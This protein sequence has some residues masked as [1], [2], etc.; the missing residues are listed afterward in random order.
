V[1][2]EDLRNSLDMIKPD[3]AAKK[4]MLGNILYRTGRH[5]D[6]KVDG[7]RARSLFYRAVPAFA[8]TAVV[9]AGILIYAVKWK[10]REHPQDDGPG[11]AADMAREDAPAMFIDQ[12]QIGNRHYVLLT[13]DLREDYGLPAAVDE[14]DIG[15]EIADIGSSPDKSLTGRGVY[16]YVPAGGEAVV[17]VR[18][19]DGYQLYRFFVFESYNNNQD[20]DA[21]EYLK[22]Y[23]I[24]S[25]EDIAK[26]R[27]IGHSERSKELGVTDIRGEITGR[28]GIMRFYE[29]FSALKNSS[30]KYFDRLFN[31]S[32]TPAGNYSI[33]I[34]I[35]VPSDSGS[36]EI[37]IEERERMAAAE[38]SKGI[39]VPPDAVGPDTAATGQSGNSDIGFASAA[40]VSA[41]VPVSSDDPVTVYPT[42]PANP[43]AS[44]SS[45]GTLTDTGDGMPGSVQGS[46]GSVGNALENAITIRIYN[47]NGIY[48]DTVY[49]RNIGFISRY[50]ISEGFAA[51]I[52]TML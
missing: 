38:A 32:S 21:I 35:S 47:K 50:E 5:E 33:E 52:S 26:I 8:L 27:F 44:G 20:E 13:D 43:S 36:F 30:D 49:Y 34:D 11:L 7:R 51:F 31:Y 1:K 4:R 40:P 3:E 16:R 46:P 42:A 2:K 24:N 39:A 17:A 18:K 23:G 25:A 41:D 29:Y 14:G 9:A 15:E 19:D 22:L 12:F 45:G 28:E 37:D 10:N 48:F 6:R